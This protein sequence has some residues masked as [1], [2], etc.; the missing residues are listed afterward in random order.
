M[1]EKLVSVIVT[2]HKRPDMLCAC[3]QSLRA[4][5]AHDFEI[6]VVNDGKLDY[7]AIV[8]FYG[9]QPITYVKH[10]RNRGLGAARNTGIRV[11]RGRY[12]MF[13]DDD[14][15]LYP[16]HIFLLAIFLNTH[17]EAMI[18]FT[19]SHRAHH[20]LDEGQRL[21]RKGDKI[22]ILPVDFYKEKMLSGNFIPVCCVMFRKELLN[23]VGMFDE[24]L[25]SHED[26]DLW[27]R[28]AMADYHFHHIKEITAEISWRPDT[29]TSNTAIMVSGRN[30]VFLR[31]KLYLDKSK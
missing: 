27:S 15:V 12:L 20:Y 9:R 22:P 4:Q 21:T 10:D 3:L 29:M 6:I 26:W 7:E 14:D 23:K 25:E 17:P 19:D 28:M 18:V 5:R 1:Q 2:S 11:S 31:N 24:E 8:D 30:K 13:L 16:N